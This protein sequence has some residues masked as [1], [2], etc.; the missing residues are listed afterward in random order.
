ML[1]DTL[2]DT[3]AK[4]YGLTPNGAV[5]IGRDGKVAARQRWFEPVALRQMIDAAVA[6]RATPN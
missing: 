2:D 3:V 5:V 4:A 1:V 6:A